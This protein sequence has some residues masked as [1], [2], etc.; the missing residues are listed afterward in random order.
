MGPALGLIAGSGR[1]PVL[2]AQGM[3]AAGQPSAQLLQSMR[4]VAAEKG[5]A[6]PP[7]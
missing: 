1:L 3:K 2:V 6:R 4:N 7:N 5:L